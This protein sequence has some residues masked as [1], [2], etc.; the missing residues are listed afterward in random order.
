MMIPSYL[1]VFLLVFL[2]TLGVAGTAPWIGNSQ[3]P[4]VWKLGIGFFLALMVDTNVPL[5]QLFPAH[6]A[7]TMSTF[8]V[9]AVQETMV[10]IALGLMMNLAFAAVEFAGSLLDIQIGLSIAS[11]V[12]PGLIGPVTILSNLQY[13]LFTM[14]F[15]AVNGHYAIILAILQSFRVLPLGV[16]QFSGPLAEVMLR[17]TADLFVLGLQMAAPV[18]LA[19]FITNLSLAVASRAVQ[20]L[21]VFAIGLP[22]SLLVG[23]IVL[24]SVM[25]DFAYA[26][27]GLLSSLETGVNDTLQ[28]MGG[29]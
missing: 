6:A 28:A 13:L 5:Q 8:L 10:G 1:L 26:F 27:Q 24:S 22:V 21:N 15:L 16:A 19:L 17:G 12:S 4:A 11:I 2:R 18:L 23:F 3:V 29:I 7:L 25:P 14:W 20:Q 9:I